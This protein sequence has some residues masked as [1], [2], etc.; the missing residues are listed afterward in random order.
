M[1]NTTR[2]LVI[3]S[4]IH[5]R[6]THT[7]FVKSVISGGVVC[8]KSSSFYSSLSRCLQHLLTYSLQ[9]GDV[10]NVEE[11]QM[12]L[13]VLAQ[14]KKLW[15]QQMYLDIGAKAIHLRDIQSQV[16]TDARR[17]TNRPVCCEQLIKVR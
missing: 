2:H 10:Q 7:F 4:R 8:L 17:S 13:S 16:R 11:A 1:T 14:N 6:R 15:S 3:V 5:L 9:D 12:R